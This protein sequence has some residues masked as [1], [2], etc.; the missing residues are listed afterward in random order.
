M[1]DAL[2]VRDLFG[3][4]DPGTLLL[5]ADTISR[6]MNSPDREA[7]LRADIDDLVQEKLLADVLSAE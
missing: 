6:G 7:R 2:T 3:Y 1:D 5:L 4:L